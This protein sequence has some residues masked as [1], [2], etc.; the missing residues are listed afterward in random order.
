VPKKN[1]HS[2]VWA[3]FGLKKDHE[4][5]DETVICCLYYTIVLVRGGNATNLFSHLKIHHA[6]EHASIEKRKKKRK[7]NEESQDSGK[8]ISL[9]EAVERS[10]LA[11]YTW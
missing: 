5:N 7:L 4:D 10:Q 11:L 8:Q 3:F 1:T 2:P 9:G 6:K